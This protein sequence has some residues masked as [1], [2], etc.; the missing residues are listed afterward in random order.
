MKLLKIVL[1]TLTLSL[2]LKAQEIGIAPVKIWTNNYELQNPVGF[3]A[4]FF[5]PIWKLGIKFEYSMAFNNRDY[6]GAILTGY[7]A[8]PPILENVNS[9]SRYQTYEFSI[10]A[11]SVNIHENINI[12][13]AVGFSFDS[14]ALERKGKSTGRNID[15]DK[16][17]KNGYFYSI[18][19]SYG[20]LFQ[21]PI[22]LEVMFKQKSL[23][24]TLHV[25]DIEMP[26]EDLKSMNV[27]QVNIAYVF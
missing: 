10:A 6:Y 16:D 4:F 24:S 19:V 5:Q 20:K 18:A 14:F 3:S 27:L 2:P 12:N 25:E 7:M 23:Y 15:F 1:I 13:G 17:N 9:K 21:L 11:P 8:E 26:F 22:K